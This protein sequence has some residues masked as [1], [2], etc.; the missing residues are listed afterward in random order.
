MK[1]K[2]P[3]QPENQLSI[4]EMATFCKR[5]GFVYQNSEIYGSLAGFFDFGP[6]GVELKNNIKQHWWKTFVQSRDDIVGIDGSI[7]THP[8]VWKAS[9]HVDSFTDILVECNKC[10]ARHR[11]DHLIEDKLGI[12]T[13]GMSLDDLAKILKES[14]IKCPKCGNAALGEPKAFNLMFTTNIGPIETENSRAYLRPETAQVI[15]TDFRLVQENARLK[16]PFGI[17]Q[18]G[19]AYRN[20]IS[21][22]DFLF[23]M[24]EFEQMEIEYFTHPDSVNECPYLD[25]VLNHEIQI[26]SEDMQKHNKEHVKMSIR[27]A[28]QKKIIKTT[29]HAYWLAKSHK[30][31]TSLGAKLDNFRIRQHIPTELSHYALETWDLEYKFP[32]GWKELQ[33]VA[34]RTDYD[35]QQHIKHSGKD[36]SLFD[37]AT[38]RKI[39]PHVVCEPSQGVERA[40]LVF[41]FDAY[42][43]N[44]ERDNIVLK[45]HPALAPFKVAVFPL[46]SN[47]DEL[48]KKAK[49]VHDNLKPYFA[50]FYDDSGSIG[51][52]YARQDESGTPY[53]ITIDFDTLNND[54]VTI[55]DRDSTEQ[56]RIKIK[57]LRHKLEQLLSKE[58]HFSDLKD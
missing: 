42:T 12:N 2:A 43:Y 57:E 8:A 33:G 46:V 50:S 49:E 27:E 24:R 15:F 9:G 36:L 40:F 21:P 41:M 52:R 1:E 47:K 32:F 4:E 5:K 55:R 45:L 7:I 53:C 39:I 58:T 51:R 38:K 14:P 23:R 26:L 34:N 16:L 22:R 56:H 10:K 25:E 35:L 17:A 37:E 54:T 13:T 44:P 19:K 28:L 20:E 31:F 29:W 6:L 3:K 11:A 30:W 18:I 48:V